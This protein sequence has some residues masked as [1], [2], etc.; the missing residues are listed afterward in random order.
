M[1]AEPGYGLFRAEHRPCWVIER[2]TVRERGIT[3]CGPDPKALID[4]VSA[5]RLREA[6]RAELTARIANWE[7]GV[8]PTS[9]LGHRG[10]QG[11]EIETACRVLHTVETGTI[12]GK[13]DAL[14]WARSRLPSEWHPLLDFA[15]RCRKDRT[16]DPSRVEQ[17]LDFV[18]WAAE[19]A[20][21][22]AE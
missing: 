7:S 18:R 8:W 2:W 1:K 12:A 3:L 10:A 13:Q 15:E 20:S 16:Q 11:F 17:V 4:P 5:D 19:Q 21:M 22:S 9:D 6:A 14:D